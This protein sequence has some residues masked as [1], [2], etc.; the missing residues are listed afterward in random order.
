MSTMP[1]YPIEDTDALVK[2]TK[3]HE[4]FHLVNTQYREELDAVLRAVDLKH[5]PFIYAAQSV[6]YEAMQ[7]ASLQGFD[8]EELHQ[9]MGCGSH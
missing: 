4:G 6:L 5:S 9:A 8:T 3:A 2:L 1:P 7:N